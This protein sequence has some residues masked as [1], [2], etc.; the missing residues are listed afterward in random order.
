MINDVLCQETTRQIGLFK[1]DYIQQL[2]REHK[3]G[4]ADHGLKL[5][6]LITFFQWYNLFITKK[7]L[8]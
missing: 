8:I 6:G 5:L 4:R 2:L 1:W 7:V 3:S